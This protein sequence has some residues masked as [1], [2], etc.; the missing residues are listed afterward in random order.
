MRAP[1][2]RAIRALG[3]RREIESVSVAACS[4]HDSVGEVR[5]DLSSNEISSSNSPSLAV[6][7]DQIQHFCPGKHC[8]F[9]RRYL[10]EKCLI[11]A[12]QKL[13]A[14]LASRVKG[15]GNLSAAKRAI[16]KQSA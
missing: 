8:Y 12:Q 6:D 2:R 5:L 1:D 13:L 15:T 11:G 16:C 10:A 4:K 9:A 7:Y 3:I 14:R